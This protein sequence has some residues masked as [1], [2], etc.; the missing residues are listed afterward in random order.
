MKHSKVGGLG[1]PPHNIFEDL[2]SLMLI[3]ILMPLIT[4]LLLLEL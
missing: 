2:V 3:L 1:V 4:N